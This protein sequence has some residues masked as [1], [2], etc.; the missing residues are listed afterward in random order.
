MRLG[1]WRL[2]FFRRLSRLGVLLAREVRDEQ[3]DFVAKAVKV[4]RDSVARESIRMSGCIANAG[5]QSDGA[6]Q[7][8][9][10][11]FPEA[12]EGTMETAL[13]GGVM[14]PQQLINGVGAS[15]DLTDECV[16]IHS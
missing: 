8:S 2:G 7:D 11:R 6:S 14:L 12:V 9:R 16:G 1:G 15:D 3:L 4:G 5:N 10:Q 13:G